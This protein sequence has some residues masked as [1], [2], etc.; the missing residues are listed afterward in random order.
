LAI[1]ENLT[2][3]GLWRGSFGIAIQRI[4]NRYAPVNKNLILFFYDV[5]QVAVSLN[6]AI[7]V[8]FDEGV[9]KRIKSVSEQTG[10]TVSK[11]IRVA[12]E[13]YLDQ[14]ELNGEVN[15][16]LKDKSNSS[17]ACGSTEKLAKKVDYRIPRK[18]P[19]V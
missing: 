13:K 8:R 17:K 19:S 18:K 7:P 10:I 11:L 9:I 1:R 2:G 15:F 12:T 5:I 6:S 4:P 16:E 14:V 3:T